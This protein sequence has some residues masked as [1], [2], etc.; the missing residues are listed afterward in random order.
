ML[1]SAVQQCESAVWIHK[2]LPCWASLPPTPHPT[3]ML[4]FNNGITERNGAIIWLYLVLVNSNFFIVL[5][6]KSFNLHN[7]IMGYYLIV[8]HAEMLM[9]TYL[10]LADFDED[11]TKASCWSVFRWQLIL[12][13][14]FSSRYPQRIWER[15][16]HP[17]GLRCL[18][19]T[20][21]QASRPLPGS[22]PRHLQ[23]LCQMCF[24]GGRRN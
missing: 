10:H 15:P 6:Q 23:V 22:A 3:K 1:A 24:G 20:S 17:G 16:S 9:M 21:L 4:F 13:M 12:F 7:L 14:C 18:W 19:R 2:S 5:M 11:H 8:F